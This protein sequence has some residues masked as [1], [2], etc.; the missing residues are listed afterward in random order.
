MDVPEDIAEFF[1]LRVE[2]RGDQVAALDL[3]LQVHGKTTFGDHVFGERVVARER[4]DAAGNA[5]AGHGDIRQRRQEHVTSRDVDRQL[6]CAGLAF[7]VDQLDCERVPANRQE[8]FNGKFLA[9]I[10]R[11][12][13]AIDSEAVTAAD[14]LPEDAYTTSRNRD[15]LNREIRLAIDAACGRDSRRGAFLVC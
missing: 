1:F 10:D 9:R 7:R 14:S 15:V 5:V 3:A 8:V 13:L 11:Q 12:L 2:L 4:L 6:M